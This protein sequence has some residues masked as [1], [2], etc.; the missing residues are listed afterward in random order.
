MKKKKDKTYMRKLTLIS[1]KKE[2]SIASLEYSVHICQW[3]FYDSKL[4]MSTHICWE[5]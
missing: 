2:F 3:K 4:K 1:G 5:N